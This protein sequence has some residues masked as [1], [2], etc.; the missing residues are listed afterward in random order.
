[1]F[2]IYF[3]AHAVTDLKVFLKDKD[4]GILFVKPTA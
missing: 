3:S 1:M 4:S 2:H